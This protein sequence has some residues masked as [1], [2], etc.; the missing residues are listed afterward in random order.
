MKVIV[1]TSFVPFVEGGAS[2]IV[3]WLASALRDHGHEVDLLELPLSLD[4]KEMLEQMLAFR[5]LD[6][7]HTGD[8]LI[9]LR[10]PSY[11]LRHPRK[12]VW[13]I[14]HYRG[15]YDLWG[16]RYQAIPSTPEGV[17]YREAIMQADTLG[18]S[19]AAKVYCNSRLMAER[20]RKFNNIRAHVLYPPVYL[21]ERYRC[22]AF[23][24]Y[25]VYVARLTH[26]KRQWLAIEAMRHTRSAVRLVIAGAPDP[27]ASGYVLELQSLIER[28][29]LGGRVVL[30]DHWIA[31]EDK[32]ALLADCLGALYLGFDED[33]YGYASLEAQ[34]AGKPVLSTTDSGATG[35]LILDGLN[36]R[37]V[38]PDPEAIAQVMDELYWDRSQAQ[39]MGKAGRTRIAELGI[40]WDRVVGELLG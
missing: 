8:C 10:P 13:F 27:D 1:A 32:I 14:H 29:R 17:R 15:A 33:S 9:A 18:L 35:E 26:H 25:F 16:T 19:E 38:P 28:Y 39:L 6:V 36:G 20:L 7:T 4:Y 5:L 2:R 11:L 37:L 34:H 24:D 12:I 22:G 3:H 23:G 21:P 40:S 31:E 30:L